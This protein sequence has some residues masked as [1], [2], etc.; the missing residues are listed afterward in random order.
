MCSLAMSG[1]MGLPNEAFA[2]LFASIFGRLRTNRSRS[3]PAIVTKQ[4]A[5]LLV[6]T[7]EINPRLK[8]LLVGLLGLRNSFLD[9]LCQTKVLVHEVE[10]DEPSKSTHMITAANSFFQ[11]LKG[12]HNTTEP[13]SLTC[14]LMLPD[15]QRGNYL[16]LHRLQVSSRKVEVGKH[17]EAHQVKVHVHHA[18]TPPSYCGGILQGQLEPNN[19]RSL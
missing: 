16:L 15:D 14:S 4:L 12:F 5:L 3:C 1:Q 8:E 17:V 9:K 13:R 6:C 19:H 18:P 7:L 11:P 2:T 10:R